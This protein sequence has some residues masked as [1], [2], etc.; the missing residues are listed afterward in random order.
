MKLVCRRV[1][2]F[3]L[4]GRLLGNAKGSIAVYVALV[5]PVLIGIGALTIDLGRL[6]SLNTELQ[7]AADAASLACA[8]ELDRTSGARDRCYAAALNAVQNI[9][10]FAADGNAATDI[11]SSTPCDNTTPVAPCIRILKDLPANDTDSITAANVAASDGEAR[12]GEVFTRARSVNNIL[13][14]LATFGDS[15]VFSTTN[16][17]AVAGQNQVICN[18][19]PMWMCNPTEPTTNTNMEWPVNLDVLE[20]R[21]MA[22]F[23]QQG[24]QTLPGNFGLLC[25]AGEEG[26]GQGNCGGKEVKE[27]LA[28]NQGTCITLAETETKTGATLG[29]VRAGINARFDHWEPQAKTTGVGNWRTLDL[30]TPAAN[31]TQGGKPGNG[32]KGNGTKCEYKD[33]IS[34]NP[35]TGYGL[36]R[37]SCILAGP[38]NITVNTTQGPVNLGSRFGGSTPG[39]PQWA[40]LQYY[41]VNHR[42]DIAVNP[43]CKPV[44]WDATTSGATTGPAPWPPSRYD[45]YR[46]ELESTTGPGGNSL[47]QMGA[48][49]PACP[50]GTTGC[51]AG[52]DPATT[53]EEIGGVQCFTGTPPDIPGYEYFD[54]DR[55]R[56]LALLKDRRVLPIAVANCNAV[57]AANGGNLGGK[58]SFVPSEFVYIF[59]T[60]PMDVPAESEMHAEMLGTL[61]EGTMEILVRDVVQLYR[62]K[63]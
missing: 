45:T 41:R 38:C 58:F 48:V 33:D 32:I 42:C 22:L 52:G 5:T 46:Y 35:S 19:P 51:S 9:E 16:A 2:N 44:D 55:K 40:Y 63:N 20:T 30:F 56:N 37:D 12:Y 26:T 4:F 57:K 24:S 8:R 47:V 62:R 34:D 10:T 11:I 31:V 3:S 7:S 28:S 27:A 43:T 23:L 59:L 25:P 39:N 36:P 15:A 50:A 60:E 14:R 53:T 18:V 13:I 61:D 21:S 29:P 1:K 54:N 17:H 49:V 6:M